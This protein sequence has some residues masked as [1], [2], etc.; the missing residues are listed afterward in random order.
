MRLNRD[1]PVWKI[2]TVYLVKNHNISTSNL[3]HLNHSRTLR[4][5]AAC[6]GVTC[7]VTHVI[8]GQWS[9]ERALRYRQL[10]YTVQ[11]LVAMLPLHIHILHTF[12]LSNCILITP[13]M[14]QFTTTHDEIQ[15]SCEGPSVTFD[16]ALD[17]MVDLTQWLFVLETSEQSRLHGALPRCVQLCPRSHRDQ[18]IYHGPLFTLTS[19]EGSFR[20]KR[21]PEE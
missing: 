4:L 18:C 13:V 17:F 9:K 1:L 21:P 16:P 15:T 6:C 12:F 7:S 10:C 20:P 8:K 11:F 5:L 14:R 3:K 19:L 2:S